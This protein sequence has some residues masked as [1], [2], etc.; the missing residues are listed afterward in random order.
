MTQRERPLAPF[1][2]GPYYKPQ[3]TTVMSLMHRITGV[4][5]AVGG[6][7]LLAWLVAVMR[8]PDAYA[9][10]AD[11]A[12]SLPGRLMLGAFVF[13]LAYHFFNGIRHLAWDLG[14][15]FSIKQ[16]YASGWTVIALTTVVT[17][18]IWFF[19][20]SAGGAL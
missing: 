18:L 9:S 11:C 10:F 20:I 13:A 15:G 12:G 3:I 17:L 4:I 2:I 19:G 8:G 1:M 16:L 14:L 6:F 5:L 7:L